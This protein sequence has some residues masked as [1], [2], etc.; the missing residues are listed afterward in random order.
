MNILMNKCINDSI[1]L[2]LRNVVLLV[3]IQKIFKET[4]QPTETGCSQLQG[5]CYNV[6]NNVV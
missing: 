4:S 1:I 2:M 3:Y 5:K 6:I